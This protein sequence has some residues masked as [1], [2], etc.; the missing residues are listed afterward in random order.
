MRKW[1]RSENTSH[2]H[3]SETIVFC[4]T[5]LSC[6]DVYVWNCADVYVWNFA[7]VYV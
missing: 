6:A 4:N 7:D 2:T 3:I 5:L 1:L